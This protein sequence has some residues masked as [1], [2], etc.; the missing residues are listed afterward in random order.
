MR[1]IEGESNRRTIMYFYTRYGVA[2]DFALTVSGERRLIYR[3][4]VCKDCEGR[5]ADQDYMGLVNVSYRTTDG[6]FARFM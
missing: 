2:R 6:S 3:G 1:A 5:R 4:D